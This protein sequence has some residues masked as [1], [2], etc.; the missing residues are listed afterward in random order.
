MILGMGVLSAY[1]GSGI[2]HAQALTT[3]STPTVVADGLLE[4]IVVTASKRSEAQQDVASQMT[5]LPGAALEDINA[6]DS[7]RFAPLVPGLRFQRAR[8]VKPADP[9]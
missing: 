7:G 6:T 9:R 8:L 2:A 4:T 1:V 5:A 3:T